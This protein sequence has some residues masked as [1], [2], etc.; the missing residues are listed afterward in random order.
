VF[1]VGTDGRVLVRR[2]GNPPSLIGGTAGWPIGDIKVPQGSAIHAVSR[3]RDNSST[4]SRTDVTGDI[5][6]AA[7]EPSFTD[8]AGTAGGGLNGGK[9]H[10]PGAP[11]TAVS[12]SNRQGS[13]V[14]VV[15]ID[16][17]RVDRRV[18]NPPFTDWW[19]GWWPIRGLKV[20]QGSAIHRG[21]AQ[22]N[23]LDIFAT[24]R[25]RDIWTAAW[26]P[27]FLT[28]GWHG[29]GAS[30][31]QGQAWRSGKP[32]S[33][34][35]ADKL[36]VFRSRQHRRSRMA[37]RVGTLLPRLVARLVASRGL[38]GQVAPCHRL[39]SWARGGSDR[40]CRSAVTLLNSSWRPRKRN[41]RLGG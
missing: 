34:R 14:F 32:R 36:D 28:D 29:G 37:G 15:G 19:H 21:L 7:W 41:V 24:D 10:G 16:S 18:G 12:R 31:R 20:P 5:W 35:S 17:P 26:E 4:S 9:T 11:V 1:V 13:N 33:P 3:S 23:K 22:P 38:M 40:P 27:S 2:V 30:M 39:R 6:T 25:E 8:V